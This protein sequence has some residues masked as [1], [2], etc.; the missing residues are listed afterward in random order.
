MKKPQAERD[1]A[2]A[3]A[4]NTT[5]SAGKAAENAIQHYRRYLAFVPGDVGVRADYGRLLVSVGAFAQANSQLERV[6]R[7]GGGDDETRK[8]LVDVAMRLGLYPSAEHHLSILLDKAENKD[9]A[10]LEKLGSCQ[11]LR[12]E[13][14]KAKES[15]E[16]AIKNSPNQ[17]TSYWLL[18]EVLRDRLKNPEAARKIVDEMADKNP[19]NADAHVRRAHFLLRDKQPLTEKESLAEAEKACSRARELQPENSDALA[20]AS[21]CQQRKGDLVAARELLRQ[22]LNH[23][24]NVPQR[25]LQ[26]AGL[27]LAGLDLLTSPEDRK[28]RVDAAIDAVRQGIRAIPEKLEN[29]ELRWRL[30]DLLISKDKDQEEIAELE[31]LVADLSSSAVKS[32]SVQTLTRRCR[33]PRGTSRLSGRTQVV[34]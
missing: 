9:G 16:S 23:N 29:F 1:A 25:Y 21:N 15:L 22:S 24:P 10:L 27:E 32:K 4:R 11:L 17:L 31:A 5:A 13:Y 26:L 30:A 33:P 19:D 34:C 8:M 7:E 12:G 18:A 28:A 3:E 6:L 14:E 2:T 20:L